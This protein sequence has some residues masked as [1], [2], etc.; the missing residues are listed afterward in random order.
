M[1][2]SLRLATMLIVAAVTLC[3]CVFNGQE[4]ESIAQI[5]LPEP[6]AAPKNMILGERIS[7]RSTSVTLYY[8][9]T[10]GASFTAVT[11]GLRSEGG[12][13]LLE[14]AVNALLTPGPGGQVMYFSTADTRLLS[15][16]YACGLA[17]VNLSIDARNAQSEQELLSLQTA[18]GDTLLGLDGVDGVNILIGGE[19]ERFSQLPLGVQTGLIQSVT[20]AYAQLQAEKE[21]FF[22]GNVPIQRTAALY[23]PSTDGAY[24]IPETR[25]LDFSDDN[26]ANALIAA[27]REGPRDRTNA[28]TALPEDVNLLE[29]PRLITLTTGEHAVVLDYSSTLANYLAF[30]GME[31]WQLVGSVTLTL[32]SFIPELDAVR[33]LVNGEPITVCEIDGEIVRFPNGMV[34]RSDFVDRIGNVATLYLTDESGALRPVERAFSRRDALSPRCLLEALLEY[35]DPDSGVWLS[36]PDEVGSADLLGIQ[37]DNRIARVNLSADFYRA[38][39]TL[40]ALSERNLVYAIVNTL[41]QLPGVQGVR[42]YVE[43]LSAD[44]LAGT[45]YLRSTLLP[46]PGI[47]V[48]KA[49]ELLTEILLEMDG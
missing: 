38:C 45:I 5:P 40:D 39:Q 22:S 41:C 7:P 43:G 28:F 30:S 19:S 47:V 11:R 17:T 46:N 29:A 33:M 25:A 44:T 8:A 10:D 6:S 42:F 20:T 13:N 9:R 49:E 15:C 23:F 14:A 16:E 12:E 27:L 18:I 24:L 21:H 34:R 4:S 2:K 1:R 48:N 31:L 37:V 35:D 36:I 3:G 32:T 26:Y